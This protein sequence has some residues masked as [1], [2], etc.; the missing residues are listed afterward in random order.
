MAQYGDG[1]R[2]EGYGNEGIEQRD[3]YG[4]PVDHHPTPT[5]GYGSNTAATTGYGTN[6]PAGG[7]YHAGA[8][9]TGGMNMTGGTTTG[10]G[11]HRS[12][13]SSS[14]SEDEVDENG[15]RRK[16]GIKDKIKEKLPGTHH[17]QSQPQDTYTASAGDHHQNK[18]IIDKIKDKLPGSH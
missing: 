1:R 16:K 5:S 17:H 11:L 4:K 3:E 2:M 18:G 12:G 10:H 8:G 7:A 6:Y 13:S 9:T 15:V 14:S